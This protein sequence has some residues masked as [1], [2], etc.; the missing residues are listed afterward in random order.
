MEKKSALTISTVNPETQKS[1]DLIATARAAVRHLSTLCTKDEFGRF[2]GRFQIHKSL[3]E[4]GF[5]VGLPQFILFLKFMG[6]VRKLTKDGNGTCYK[7]LVV[8]PTFF[9]L[10]VTEESVS[11]VL[12][13]MYERLEVQR[14][15]NDYQR[16]IANLEEQL[17]RQPSNEEYLGTLN[18]H[19]AEVIAQVE[20]LSAENSEKT[21]KIS[22]LEAEL[23]CTTKVDAKQVTDELMA[24]F[25]QTQ[26]KN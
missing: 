1:D 17:K 7:F 25:R 4:A 24:R 18:E 5:H 19:L 12:K 11:A 13:Q 8:D 6:L 15:C 26:S 9:D 16:R 21:A 10:L 23:K 2:T 22:E 3:E 20:H 14:L